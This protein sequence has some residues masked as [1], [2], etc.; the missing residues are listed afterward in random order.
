VNPDHLPILKSHNPSKRIGKVMDARPTEDGLAITLELDAGFQLSMDLAAR[1]AVIAKHHRKD[2]VRW[3]EWMCWLRHWSRN[4]EH[5]RDTSVNDARAILKAHGFN[6]K[7]CRFL[8]GVFPRSRW[9]PVGSVHSDSGRC[10]GR[11]VQLFRP[12]PGAVF[13]EVARPEWLRPGGTHGQS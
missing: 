13:T 11:K 7:E 4:P 6:P 2:L 10:H 9:E 5:A 1:D 12:R 8:G 3:L